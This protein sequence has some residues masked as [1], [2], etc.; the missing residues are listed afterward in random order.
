MLIPFRK[1]VWLMACCLFSFTVFSQTTAVYHS[2]TETFQQGEAL[3]A[4][5]QYLQAQLKFQAFTKAQSTFLGANKMQVQLADAAYYNAVCALYL[6]QSDAEYLL[7]EFLNQYPNTTRINDT[8]YYLGKFNFEKNQFKDVIL[9]LE[10]VDYGLL[11]MEEGSNAQFYLAYSYFSTKKVDKA[12]PLFQTL[13]HGKSKYADAANYYAGYINYN[14]KNYDDALS[15]LEKAK[16]AAAYEK[17]VPFY[18]CRIYFVQKKYEQVLNYAD[19]ALSKPNVMNRSDINYIIGQTWF[20]KKDYPNALKYLRAYADENKKMRKEDLYQIAFAQYKTGLYADAIT[21][22]KDLNVLKDSLGQYAVYL[23]GD[24]YLRTYQN[25]NARAAFNQAA[26]M[27]FDKEIKEQSTF[28]AAKLAFEDGLDEVAINTLQSFLKDYP[29]SALNQEA[30]ELLTTIY[31]NTNNY[32]EAIALLETFPTKTPKLKL[33]Y[34]KAAY[35]RAVELFHDRKWNEAIRDFDKSIQYPIVNQL[36]ADAYYWKGE[37]YYAQNKQEEAIGAY[38]KYISWSDLD[39]NGVRKNMLSN[40]R[41]NI[42]YCYLKQLNYDLAL[43]NFK[44]CLSGLKD[45]NRL[46]ADVEL[47]IADCY[48]I[49]KDY[50]NA[51]RYYDHVI[52]QG[53]SG[54]DYALFQKGIILGLTDDNEGKIQTLNEV[55]AVNPRSIYI[56]DAKFEIG[57]TYFN[58]EKYAQAEVEYQDVIANYPKSIFYKKARMKLALLYVNAEQ[59]DKAI[60]AYQDIIKDYPNSNESTEALLGMKN[61]YIDKG[62]ANGFLDFLR[63]QPNAQLNASAED[64]LMYEA[65]ESNYNNEKYEDARK[66]FDDY[67]TR[68]PKGFFLLNAY[69]LRAECAAKKKDYKQAFADYEAVAAMSNNKFTERTL[70]NCAQIA[71]YQLKNYEKALIYYKQ[72][73][74]IASYKKNKAEAVA[75]A[76]R[77]AYKVKAKDDCNRYAQLLLADETTADDERKEANYYIGKLAYDAGD[78]AMA[79]KALSDCARKNKNEYAA[80]SNYLLAVMKYKEKDLAGAES[81]C[82]DLINQIPSYDKWVGECLLLLGDIYYDE[83][84]YFQAKSTLETLKENMKNKDLI[85]RADKKLIVIKQAEEVDSKLMNDST[86][87][88]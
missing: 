9:Y 63:A 43:Q 13:A 58:Q 26:K 84:E 47:R 65:A 69:F 33:A 54:A 12:K 23:L 64:S 41:Y 11:S 72:L 66:N 88:K 1:S 82:Y 80:E 32:D 50:E 87:E 30:K 42:A 68:F 36:V 46:W 15:Y 28:N 38:S 75:G 49:D 8:R 22:L 51:T 67:L 37:V 86:K 4:K 16:N 62:D 83:K 6:N 29:S 71:Y 61:I 52:K 78:Y 24:C 25:T 18:I 81:S 10:Q 44:S 56:D 40:A 85:D 14:Q 3:F 7:K 34:Q 31:L 77:S 74:E 79:K 2:P 27:E 53:Q 35:Y 39:S 19:E 73:G 60:A 48:F 5:Q 55:G 17:V 20:Q 57:N 59:N 76:M 21:N 45:K 70:V